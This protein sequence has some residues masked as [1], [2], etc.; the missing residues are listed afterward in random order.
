[1]TLS[2][3]HFVIHRSIFMAHRCEREWISILFDYDL[4]YLHEHR[5]KYGKNKF[6][7]KA[8]KAQNKWFRL[9]VVACVSARASSEC[10]HSTFKPCFNYLSR[11]MGIWGQ[12]GNSFLRSQWRHIICI[13]LDT[14]MWLLF[15]RIEVHSSSIWF[16]GCA[17]DYGNDRAMNKMW[18]KK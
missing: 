15:V 6:G 18:K 13:S 5:A 8:N 11:K 14:K 9:V 4:E 1:M 12:I 2:P 10:S 3:R 16:F 17:G 7:N